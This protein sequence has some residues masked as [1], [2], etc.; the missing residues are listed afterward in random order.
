MDSQRLLGTHVLAF[1]DLQAVWMVESGGHTW[2]WKA[3]SPTAHARFS[4]FQLN[5]RELGTLLG[6]GTSFCGE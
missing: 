3:G 6:R 2:H 4:I 5:L 1:S